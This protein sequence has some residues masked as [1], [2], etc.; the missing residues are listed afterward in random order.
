MG[1]SAKEMSKRLHRLANEQTLKILVNAEIAENEEKLI[2]IKK[3]EYLDGNI[4]SRPLI[5]RTYAGG[6]WDWYRKL[7]LEQNPRADGFV[8]LIYKGGF[9]GGF[10]ITT[11]GK[12]YTFFS[13]DSKS[14]LLKEKYNN[15]KS[16]IFDLDQ[17][18]FNEFINKYVKQGFV[19]AL[20]Q[21]L[22]Q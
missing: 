16:D 11:K 14:R 2:A 8:D 18:V 5:R 20:K 12:G 17:N 6:V 21:Q 22:G 10:E 15:S 4:Y 13:T 9:I 7:K 1:I 19:K 3:E